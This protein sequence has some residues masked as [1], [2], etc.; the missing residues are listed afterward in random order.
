MF[1]F[2][3]YIYTLFFFGVCEQL[4]YLASIFERSTFPEK[5]TDLITF[6]VNFVVF[7]LTNRGKKNRE[8]S[9]E[10]LEKL[11]EIVS[12]IFILS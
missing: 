2:N 5:I 7:F 3:F 1:V 11:T 6:F 10:K 8:K 12:S 4:F 9:Q